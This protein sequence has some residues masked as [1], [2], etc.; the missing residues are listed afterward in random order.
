MFCAAYI[1]T[2]SNAICSYTGGPSMKLCNT[3][4]EHPCAIISPRELGHLFAKEGITLFD[5]TE[6]KF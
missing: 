5:L 6:L 4:K 1:T 3:I 2:F